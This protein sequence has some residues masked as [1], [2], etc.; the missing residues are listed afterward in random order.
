MRRP[1][2]D[3]AGTGPTTEGTFDEQ[4][5]IRWGSY[6]VTGTWDGT[7][8][9]ATE[10]IPAA[11]YDPAMPTPRRPRRRPRRTT[12]ELERIATE[13]QDQL[14]GVLGAY[15]GEGTDGHVLAD[16]FYDDGTLQE[17]ADETYGAGVVLVTSALVDGAV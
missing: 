1:G 14:P 4:G 17:W 12:P 10:A 5:D 15:G 11:L 13:L 3:S 16:V 2:A 6:A 9:T 7:S 8:F